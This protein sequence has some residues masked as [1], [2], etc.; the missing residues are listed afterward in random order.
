MFS[1]GRF[2]LFIITQPNPTIIY[3]LLILT[4]IIC[5]GPKFFR[6]GKMYHSSL[7]KVSVSFQVCQT[8]TY[9]NPASLSGVEL[10][11]NYLTQ[12][13]RVVLIAPSYQTPSGLIHRRHAQSSRFFCC[14]TDCTNI[15][16]R[17]VSL[18]H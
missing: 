16:T 2:F 5:T 15:A 18:Y 8:L 11:S 4:L 10:A 17:S 12:H 7:E 3:R 14:S 6:R 9:K 13:I 1:S